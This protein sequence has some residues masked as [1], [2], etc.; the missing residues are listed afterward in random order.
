MIKMRK[1]K[2]AKTEKCEN[3]KIQLT[4]R[5]E[6]YIL[7]NRRKNREQILLCQ[8]PGLVKVSTGVMKLEKLSAG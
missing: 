3:R 4:I 1:Q 6:A 8:V 2:N 7:K 5:Y